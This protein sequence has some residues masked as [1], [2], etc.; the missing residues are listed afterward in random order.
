MSHKFLK[1][2]DAQAFIKLKSLQKCPGIE[3]G[4]SLPF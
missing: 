2:L 1:T 4:I 3:A